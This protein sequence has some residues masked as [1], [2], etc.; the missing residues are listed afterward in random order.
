MTWAQ[1]EE[2]YTCVT[3]TGL[4]FQVENLEAERGIAV[5]TN[6]LVIT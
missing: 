5:N 6:A 4:N 1:L 3:K 2:F